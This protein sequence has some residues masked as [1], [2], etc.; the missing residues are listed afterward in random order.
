ML[1]AV[2][3]ISVAAMADN[4]VDIRQGSATC[5]VPG[6]K[7]ETILAVITRVEGNRVYFTLTTEYERPVNAQVRIDI[8]Y[9]GGVNW[10]TTGGIAPC[11]G[12]ESREYFVTFD[13]KVTR[14]DRIHVFIED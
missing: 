2:V 12:K 6:A 4:D 8:D 10:R 11:C 13:H 5:K 9:S 14:V 7:Y 1:L 3:G